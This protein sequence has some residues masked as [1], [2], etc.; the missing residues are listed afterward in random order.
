MVSPE[1]PPH[2]AECSLGRERWT[3]PDLRG[4]VAVVTGASRNAGRGIALV[5]AEC[6]A[7]VYATGRS[8]RGG[9]VRT[10]VL[11][12]GE[13]T[14]LSDTVDETAE[15]ATARGR[16]PGSRGGVCIAVPC[17]HADDAQVEALFERVRREQGRLDLLVNNVW[18]GYEDM[19]RFSAPFW[20]QPAWRWE[21]MFN[22]GARAHYIASRLAVPLMLAGRQERRGLI[23]NTSI[24]WPAERYD[25]RL[26]YWLAKQTVNQ[27]AWAMAQELRPHGIA[28][29][30]VSPLACI[31]GTILGGEELRAIRAALHTP[32][33][34]ETLYRE[35]PDLLDCQTLEY[36][37]RAVAKLAADPDVLAKSGRVL[38]VRDLAA[39]YDF[40]DIDGRRPPHD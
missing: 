7:T 20:E 27:L 2:A 14:T 16:A 28:A 31:Q 6:G 36:M 18:G 25:G 21:A 30:A 24:A 40:T 35:R 38:K 8:V 39:A 33:G 22:A 9:P 29:V 4:R 15:L 10:Q 26:V 13:T 3:A 19:V 11:W 23:A 34:L 5:L 17:D 32:G 12:T 1:Q 37:G